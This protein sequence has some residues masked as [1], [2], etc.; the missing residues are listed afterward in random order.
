VSVVSKEN[1]TLVKEDIH[2]ED[3]MKFLTFLFI[4]VVSTTLSLEGSSFSN[5]L[6]FQYQTLTNKTLQRVRAPPQKSPT[7][8]VVASAAQVNHHHQ[9]SSLN[10]LPKTL[11]PHR[12]SIHQQIYVYLT[13]IFLTCLIVADVIGVK[14][15]ELKLPFKILGYSSIEHTCGM[16]TFP[17]TFLLGDII[18][19]YYGARATR[20]T[21][22][23]GLYMSILVFLAMNIAQ[24]MPFLDKPFNGKM[25][26]G[27][28]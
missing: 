27:I 16:V 22:Y 21:V 14:V 20:E 9:L 5:N 11:P 7:S 6:P 1:A 13:S 24:A 25:T 15:F 28:F 8:F 18:N 19:E 12:L 23:I 26:F 10:E 17:V 4:L 2:F 3:K